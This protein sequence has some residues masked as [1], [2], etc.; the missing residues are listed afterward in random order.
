M[1]HIITDFLCVCRI[2]ASPFQRLGV[3]QHGMSSSGLHNQW[4]ITANFVQISF[5]DVFVIFNPPRC[6]VYLVIRVLRYKFLD[7]FAVFGVIGHANR[8]EVCL[9]DKAISSEMAMTVRLEEAGVD[10]VLTVIQH[11]CVLASEFLRFFCAADIGKH[12]VLY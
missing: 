12:A 2:N 6:S 8:H 11:L 7:N 10:E 4:F 9:S 1:N 3:E 5:A